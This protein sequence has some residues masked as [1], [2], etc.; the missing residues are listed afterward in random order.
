MQ[1]F[2]YYNNK[3]KDSLKKN[4]KKFDSENLGV[5]HEL[6]TRKYAL[7]KNYAEFGKFF[8]T[9]P[10]EE[11]CFYEMLEEGLPRKPYFDIDIDKPDNGNINFDIIIVSLKKIIIDMIG[12][13][14]SI[15]VF[16]SHTD[17]KNSY[18]IVVDKVFLKDHLECQIFYE[19]T[20]EKIKGEHRKYIDPS[21]YKSVQQFRIFGCHKYKKKNIK[22]LNKE[23]SYNFVVPERFQK[24]N[25]SIFNYILSVFLVSNVSYCRTLS[26]FEVPVTIKSF[27]NRGVCQESDLENVLNIFYKKYNYDNYTFS[28]IK[29]KE[30]NLLITFR[31]L[32]SDYCHICKRVHENENPYVTVTGDNRNIVFYCRRKEEKEGIFLGSL[33]IPK[34]IDIKQE[35]IPKIYKEEIKFPIK[36]GSVNLLEDLETFSEEIYVDIPKKKKKWSPK[37]VGNIIQNKSLLNHIN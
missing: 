32:N 9:V 26:G 7:F 1:W 18:H 29:E 2:H 14:I 5:C 33:G 8:Q 6:E 28:E 21:V 31:R 4:I 16:T 19:K 27:F 11:R 24:N 37:K 23:L 34:E 36:E 17:K 13:D 22:I 12:E 15:L 20:V 30:G 25:K 3:E 35:D 10:K